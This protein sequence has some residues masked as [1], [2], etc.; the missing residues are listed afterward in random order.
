MNVVYIDYLLIVTNI[1]EYVPLL[2]NI[3]HKPCRK[4]FPSERAQRLIGPV[5]PII[6]DLPNNR[7]CNSGYIPELCSIRIHQFIEVS[8]FVFLIDDF[9]LL[10]SVV[11]GPKPTAEMCEIF[12]THFLTYDMIEF[13]KL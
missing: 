12:G 5:G 3:V 2:R 4:I 6:V 10:R 7:S 8:I 9:Q 1:L 13:L 11:H